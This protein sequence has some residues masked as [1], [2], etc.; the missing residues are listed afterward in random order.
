MV[1]GW[2]AKKAKFNTLETASIHVFMHVPDVHVHAWME[3][4]IHAHVNVAVLCYYSYFVS[5]R[6]GTLEEGSGD[7]KPESPTKSE[8]KGREC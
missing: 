6:R 8:S 5:I 3:L 4:H 7:I 2:S 1:Q